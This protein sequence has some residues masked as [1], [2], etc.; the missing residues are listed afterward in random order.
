M[1]ISGVAVIVCAS[2]LSTA[3]YAQSSGSE[4]EKIA[5]SLT[6]PDAAANAQINSLEGLSASVRGDWVA[7]AALAA[8]AYRENPNVTNEF[9]L[10]TSY[11]RIGRSTLA[12]PL[13]QDLATRGQFTVTHVVY[14]Y[15]HE[16]GGRRMDQFISDEASRRLDMIAGLPASLQP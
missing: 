8:K 4:A 9:N 2:V 14:D 10:A 3:T 1:K 16:G 13:Y 6:K 11:Q 5:Q 15:R 7:A 12:I